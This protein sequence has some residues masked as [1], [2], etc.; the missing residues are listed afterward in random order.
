MNRQHPL[1]PMKCEHT[2]RF[3]FVF[4]VGLVLVASAAG[5]VQAQTR[6]ACIGE[7]TTHSFHRQN[8]PE[9]PLFLGELLDRDFKVDTTR[10]HP[11]AGGFLYGGGTNYRI[12]NFGHPRGTVL[13]HALENPKAILRS[14]ELKLAEAFAPQVVILGPFGD[15]ESLTKVSMDG[16]ARDLRT[17]VDRIAGFDSKPTIF[18]ALP[19]SRGG[20]DDDANYRRIHE[21]TDQVARERKLPVIDLWSAFLGRKEY[22]QDATHLTVAGRQHLAAV[23]AYAVLAWKKGR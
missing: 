14:D 19:L 1:L 2:P 20:T 18:V 17:L 12:G 8:D 6:V 15:H 7:Q 23:I 21:E 5:Q 13:D 4:T 11:N 10:S 16:F 9:Y 22:Y 3:L